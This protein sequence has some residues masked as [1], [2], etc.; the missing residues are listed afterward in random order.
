VTLTLVTPPAA[1]PILIAD[2]RA[3][4]RLDATGSPTPSHPDDALVL[5]LVKAARQHLDGRDGVL[6][7]ALI[8]QT[9]RLDL[10]EFPRSGEAIALPLPPLVS[11][12][13]IAYTDTAGD[14]QTLSA[15]LY[16]VVAGGWGPGMVRPVHGAYWPATRAQSDAVR[17]TFTA[18]YGA[19]GSD[20]PAP[21]VAAMKL[22]LGV[23]YENREAAAP[24][25]LHAVPFAYD[26][27]ITPY[28][29]TWF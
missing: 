6:G 1:E 14:T 16:D 7:R 24:A 28:R 15:L 27:L 17:I 12:G 11:V 18:G 25:V 26:A 5:S 13:S 21:L 9:W 19:A 22:H 2:A 20:L 8:T 29:V 3:H 10:P 4:L 23:L